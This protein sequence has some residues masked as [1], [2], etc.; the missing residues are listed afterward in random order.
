MPVA[1]AGPRGTLWQPRNGGEVWRRKVCAVPERRIRLPG[2]RIAF[3]GLERL[4]IVL[5]E[6]ESNSLIPGKPGQYN[7]KKHRGSVSSRGA[8]GG[9]HDDQEPRRSG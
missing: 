3:G 5:D 9:K 4:D 1:G 2:E 7:K 8:Q 6:T